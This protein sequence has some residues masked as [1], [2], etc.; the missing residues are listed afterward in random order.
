MWISATQM[1]VV[2]ALPEA[3]DAASASTDDGLSTGFSTPTDGG[4]ETAH[5]SYDTCRH[6]L[7]SAMTT[8]NGPGIH[9]GWDPSTP[10]GW[11]SWP[12]DGC[13]ICVATRW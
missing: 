1:R 2:V 4:D 11:D 10:E 3:S 6:E 5:S 7:T 8:I 12:R 13:T 9:I